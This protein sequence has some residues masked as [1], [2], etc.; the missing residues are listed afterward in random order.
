V[1]A[2]TCANLRDIDRWLHCYC[3]VPS[4]EKRLTPAI[5]SRAALVQEL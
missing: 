1:P 2:R 5:L 3:L 4:G